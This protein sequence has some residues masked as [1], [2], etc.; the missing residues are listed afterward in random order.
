MSEKITYSLSVQVA[1]GPKISDSDTLEVEAYDK[2]QVTLADGDSDIEVDIQ[3]GGA[4]LAQFVSVT[5]T[6]YDNTL[7]Y[8]VNAAPATAIP[9][10]G[11]H[12]FIGAGAVSLLDPAPIKLFFTNAT[13]SNVTVNV[14]VG[15]DA[16]P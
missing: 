2:T 3:P 9:L 11:P 15:R 4:G 14:L 5:A 16:T 13:G 7:T 12:L 10:D 6:D 8:K 1:G